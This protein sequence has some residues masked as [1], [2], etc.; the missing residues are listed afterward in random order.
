MLDLIKN[1][2]LGLFVNGSFSLMNENF[3]IASFVITFGS[4]ALMWA[5]IYL[6]KRRK[7][8]A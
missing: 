1:I 7:N 5:C 4:I 2:G 3:T 8:G 6:S